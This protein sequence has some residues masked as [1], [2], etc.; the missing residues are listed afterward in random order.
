M[1]FRKSIAIFLLNA[2]LLVAGASA[3]HMHAGVIGAPAAIEASTDHDDGGCSF[4]HVV[5]ER[6]AVVDDIEEYTTLS[7]VC[8]RE[9]V[10]AR[11]ISDRCPLETAGRAPPRG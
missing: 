8:C 7:V 1:S 2:F 6:I 3:M 10:A 5:K 9:L 4:C 11:M